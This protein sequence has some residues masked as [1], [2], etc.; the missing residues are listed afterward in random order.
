MGRAEVAAWRQVLDTIRQRVRKLIAEG[1]T[2]EQ[3]VA[4][5][6]TADLDAKVGGNFITPD[7]IVEAAYTSM[8]ASRAPA[9]P[10]AAGA[11]AKR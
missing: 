7:R 8:T 6:P 1:K 2:L 4:A 5:K 3:A 10:P 9:R 11:P